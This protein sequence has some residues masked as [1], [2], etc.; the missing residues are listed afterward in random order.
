MFE[1]DTIPSEWVN[2]CNAMDEIWVPTEFHR[3]T[4][5]AAGVLP[6]KLVVIPEPV[7]VDRF[8]PDLAWPKNRQKLLHR[9]TGRAV[10]GKRDVSSLANNHMRDPSTSTQFLS[11]FKWETRK[12]WEILLEAYVSEFSA[13]DNVRLVLLT[14][15]FHTNADLSDQVQA[16]VER[17]TAKGT[18]SPPY[19]EVIDTHVAEKDLPYLYKMS[20]VFVLPSHGEGWGRPHVEAMA[21]Q[22]PVIATNWSGP[23]AYLDETNGFPLSIDGLVTVREGPFRKFNKWAQ[24]STA[25]LRQLLRFTHEHPEVVESRGLR[26]REDM[27]RRFNP[28]VVANQVVQRLQD[29]YQILEDEGAV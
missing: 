3:Q 18:S 6:T 26:A 22:V 9:L 16:F 1:T 24:P 13:E 21:M 4:F 17:L 2:R 5:A 19:I 7:D 15:A 11:I 8:T 14:N 10:V 28:R 25:H 29:I 27:V 20:D 12:G 23:T